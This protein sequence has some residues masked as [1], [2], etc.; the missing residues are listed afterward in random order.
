MLILYH[1]FR[2]YDP[3][4]SCLVDFHARANMASVKN[5][6]LVRSTPL[7]LVTDEYAERADEFILQMGKVSSLYYYLFYDIYLI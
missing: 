5:F 3:L 7:R 4:S 2:R 6:Q 1:S